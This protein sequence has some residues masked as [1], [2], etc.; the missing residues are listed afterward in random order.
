MTPEVKKLR[1]LWETALILLQDSKQSHGASQQRLVIR[2]QKRSAAV[3][4]SNEQD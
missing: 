3:I 1:Q 2:Q 4:T